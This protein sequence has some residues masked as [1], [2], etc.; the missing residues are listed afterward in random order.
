MTP[1]PKI[2]AA[3]RQASEAERR[4]RI[5]RTVGDHVS[6]DVDRDN[7]DDNDDGDQGSDN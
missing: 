7:D 1:Q 3:L 5:E 2:D 6:V 4:V